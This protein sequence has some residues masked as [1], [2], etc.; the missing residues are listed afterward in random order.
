MYQDKN[1]RIKF[2]GTESFGHHRLF[3]MTEK[4]QPQSH[5]QTMLNSYAECQH[6]K[7]QQARDER[8]VTLEFKEICTRQLM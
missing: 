7:N 2:R 5:K 1:V 4:Y 3:H 6:C 8:K